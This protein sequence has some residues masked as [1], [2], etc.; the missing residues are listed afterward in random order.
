MKIHPDT[1]F[2][3]MTLKSLH[4][5]SSQ[6]ILFIS[7]FDGQMACMELEEVVILVLQDSDQ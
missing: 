5:S 7:Q 1:N 3:S 2:A 4:G 6:S